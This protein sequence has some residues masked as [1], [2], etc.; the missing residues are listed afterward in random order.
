M[1]IGFSGP[2]LTTTDFQL[3]FETIKNGTTDSAGPRFVAAA[4]LYIVRSLIWEVSAWIHAHTVLPRQIA[5]ALI[6]F[7]KALRPAVEAWNNQITFN[8]TQNDACVPQEQF[9]FAL[10]NIGSIKQSGDLMMSPFQGVLGASIQGVSDPCNP[11]KWYLQDS[12]TQ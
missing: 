11:G 1:A 9:D 7:G 5:Y 8:G 6:V 10:D 4:A 2:N 3:G 12:D